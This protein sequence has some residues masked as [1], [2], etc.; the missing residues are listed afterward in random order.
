MLRKS[1]LFD[2]TL[3]SVLVL[4]MVS[5]LFCGKS[6]L[7]GETGYLAKD[8]DSCSVAEVV[9]HHF[10]F[11][12]S[13]NSAVRVSG[14][15]AECTADGQSVDITVRVNMREA[16]RFFNWMNR[17][18]YYF[19]DRRCKSVDVLTTVPTCELPSH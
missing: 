11:E 1:R 3:G 13:H 18:S 14:L 15:K 2:L 10:R 4:A 8:L 7:A 16:T 17:P 5:V 19:G 9:E 6:A 12:L